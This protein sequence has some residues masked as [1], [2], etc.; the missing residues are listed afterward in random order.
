MVTRIHT[1]C[2]HSPF[3]ICVVFIRSFL[4]GSLPHRPLPH[5]TSCHILP[6]GEFVKEN[7]L[8]II[9]HPQISEVELWNLEPENTCEILLALMNPRDNV[10]AHIQKLSLRWPSETQVKF[11]E[12]CSSA[13]LARLATLVLYLEYNGCEC[14]GSIPRR[15]WFSHI[16]HLTLAESG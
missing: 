8:R 14:D 5:L 2:S 11:N 1:V 7:L 3:I 10:P 6:F 12:F 9:S 4:T 15:I 16:S 13:R